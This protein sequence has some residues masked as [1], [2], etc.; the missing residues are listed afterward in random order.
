MDPVRRFTF[1]FAALYLVAVV[2]PAASAD[3]KDYFGI[4][5]VDEAT[6][7]GVPMVQLT[8][9]NSIRLITDSNGLAA[10]HEPGLMN[11]K[12]W[13][14]VASH[15]YE[16]P[17]D[18]FGLHGVA[19]TTTRGSTTTIRI[20]RLNVAERLY[21]ITGAGV[22]RDTVLLG[23]KAPIAEPLLNADVMGQDSVQAVEYRGKTRWFWGDT[24][25]V[26]YALGEFESTGAV[27]PPAGEIDPNIS[28]DLHYFKNDK[29][30]ARAMAP[31]KGPGVV[32]LGA[33]VVLPGDDGK[34]HLLAMYHRRQGLGEL[35]ERGFVRYD[36]A[37][38]QFE[39]V[40]QIPLKTTLSPA[41]YPVALRA[42]DQDGYLYFSCPFPTLRT[43]ADEAHYRDLSSYEAYT[44]LKAGST[45]ATLEDAQLDRD[46]SGKLVWS[47]KRATAQIDRERQAALIKAGRMKAEESPSRLI[48]ACDDKEISVHGATVAYNEYRKRYVMIALQFMGDTPVGEVWYSESDGLEGPWSKAVKII[49]HA[50]VKNDPHDFYNPVHHAFFDRDGG[51]TIYIEGTYVNTF[52]GGRA[53]P[54][55][56]YNQIMYRLDLADEHLSPSH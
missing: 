10:F 33:V 46:D 26:S 44:C 51:K 45:W 19:L 14:D 54:Y 15:G 25:R 36:D 11:R 12:V 16:M 5:V 8:T 17:A 13:F 49:T 34:P 37:E 22:Y 28:Y 3:P 6:G 30:V 2:Q 4:E 27:S 35:F 56:E 52:S 38:D 55:Y 23:R 48:A 47:W 32:W 53:T 24:T 1:W 7:R 42:G 18:G 9:T 41:G 50:N 31:I 39:K 29:G 40:E 20:K 43:R 21:R